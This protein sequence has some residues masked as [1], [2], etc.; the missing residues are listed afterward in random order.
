MTSLGKRPPE[1]DIKPEK[2]TKKAKSQ[3]KRFKGP[4]KRPHNGLI[5]PILT[6]EIPPLNFDNG[7]DNKSCKGKNNGSQ[8]TIKKLDN[9]NI[10]K[11]YFSFSP[12]K[13]HIKKVVKIMRS[14][15]DKI[16]KL[17][18]DTFFKLPKVISY[19]D[20][21]I[22]FERA[23]GIRLDELKDEEFLVA[24]ESVKYAMNLMKILKIFHNDLNLTNLFWDPTKKL[25]TIIDWDEVTLGKPRP[26]YNKFWKEHN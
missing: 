8:V 2:S 19:T 3:S 11:E 17:K 20:N 13:N 25:L 16:K 12:Q 7:I 23:Q 9:G 1:R 14:I 6:I 21:T 26:I 18:L 5:A 15:S 24:Q 4:R 22:V 10:E